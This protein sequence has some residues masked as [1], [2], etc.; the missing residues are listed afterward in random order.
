MVRI[1]AC[2]NSQQASSNGYSQHARRCAGQL[3]LSLQHEV[4]CWSSSKQQ[5]IQQEALNNVSEAA[6]SVLGHQQDSCSECLRCSTAACNWSNIRF[7]LLCCWSCRCA[8]DALQHAQPHLRIVIYARHGVTAEQLVQDAS[9][10]F[11]VKLRR[12]I[13]VGT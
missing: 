3:A 2:R 10:R 11:N 8:V 1:I 7:D 12:P 9:S 6:A 5:Q 13:E 4:P